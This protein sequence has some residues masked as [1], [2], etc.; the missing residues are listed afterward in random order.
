VLATPAPRETRNL[1]MTAAA[2]INT[3]SPMLCRLYGALAVRTRPDYAPWKAARTIPRCS[4]CEPAAL[5]A[6]EMVSPPLEL[7]VLSDGAVLLRAFAEP[8]A[9]ALAEIWRDPTIRA[10]NTVPEPTVQA[11]R[12]WVKQSAEMAAAREGWE[13]AIVDVA[14]NE[15]AGRR[16]LKQ[17]D[18]VS[19]RATAAVWV[20]SA[21]RGKQFSARSLRLAAA[22]AFASG[23]VRI[24]AECD[25]DNEASMRS[26]L[27]AGMRHEGTLR[28]NYVSSD[29]VAVDQHVLGM[30]ATD[31]ASAPALRP[32]T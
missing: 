29:G 28:S 24:Q 4:D 8:D 9:Q 1:A 27:S 26:V 11:A 19:R 31:L 3:V 22:H 15:L 20:A 6:C 10:R 32:V 7:P 18:W 16:A 2:A 12:A 21:A 14:T 25:V 13:W 30:L 17:V 23:I 5:Y